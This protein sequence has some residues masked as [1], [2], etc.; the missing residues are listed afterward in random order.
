MFSSSFHS[1]SH[2]CC[3]SNMASNSTVWNDPMKY[4]VFWDMQL[5]LGLFC[6]VMYIQWHK[7]HN[8][9]LAFAPIMWCVAT[10]YVHICNSG[11]VF[12]KREHHVQWSVQN[13]L[14]AFRKHLYMCYILCQVLLCES[15]RVLGYYDVTCVSLCAERMLTLYCIAVN[16]RNLLVRILDT[17]KVNFI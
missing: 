8:F 5:L 14:Y 11:S 15:V 16:M 3:Q 6:D 4:T 17:Y 13:H 2:Y 12:M 10:Q 9:R 1:S 7:K